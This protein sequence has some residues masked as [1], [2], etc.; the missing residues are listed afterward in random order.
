MKESRFF[1]FSLVLPLA[2]PALIAPVLFVGA[3]L[4]EW[5]VWVALYAIYS[6]II[7]G[8]PY[9]ALVGLL[10][11]WA[12][13]KSDTQF[14]RALILLPIFMVPVLAV[15]LGLGLLGEAWLR[16]ESALPVSDALLML[17]GLVP[18]ILGFGYFY[19]LLV[20]GVARVLKRRGVLVPARAI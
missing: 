9:L 2:V 8:L 11:W 20:F 15:L 12:R 17:L 4:P 3:Q 16:P 13:R 7:G 1:R 19:V 10:F 18:F 14:K 6:G 5:L